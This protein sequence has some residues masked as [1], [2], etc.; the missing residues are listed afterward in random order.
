MM[1]ANA[2]AR[3]RGRRDAPPIAY[4]RACRSPPPC[5]MPTCPC[6]PAALAAALSDDAL[7]RASNATIHERG[8]AYAAAGA[9][10]DLVELPGER[11]GVHATVEGSEAYTTW[12]WLADGTVGGRCSCPNAQDRGFCK[13]QVALALVWRA[14]LGGEAAE[15]DPAAQK[16][17]AAAA[18][19]AQTV[20]DRRQALADFLAA[21]PAQALAERL[22]ALADADREIAAALQQWRQLAQ[23]PSRAAD[24]KPLVTELLAPGRG[25]LDRRDSRVFA[26]RARGV[27]PLLAQAQ[28]RDPAGA[29]ALALHA[30]RR[31]WLVLSERADDSDGE[32]GD[33]VRAIGKAWVE[34]LKHAGPHPAA[35]GDT[36]LQVVLDD[37]FGCFDTPQAAA[38]IGPAAQQ[39]F[40]QA[41]AARWQAS[42]RDAAP[43]GATTGFDVQRW[44]VERL[45]LEQLDAEGDVDGALAVLRSDLSVPNAYRR[46]T[47]LL[48]HH[49]RLREA[50][51]NAEQGCRAFPRDPGL[52]EDLLSAYERDGW[53][54]EAL[55]LHRRRFDAA[56]SP[57]RYHAL[58][59]AAAAA[60]HDVAALREALLAAV[61]AQERRATSVGAPRFHPPGRAPAPAA[62]MFR[63]VTLR[64]ALLCSEQRWSEALALVQPPAVCATTLLV[65]LADGLGDGDTAARIALLQRAFDAEMAVATSPYRT[66]LARV[67]QIAALMAAP[68]RAA[69]LAL[70]R[71]RH[72][73]KRN[74]VQG[75]PAA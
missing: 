60:G 67:A 29:P 47:A 21:Q 18:K 36:L 49:G 25:F 50:F 54:E 34:A 5:P 11:P 73:A 10:V 68:E 62:P 38:A 13:H 72:K 75:L 35:F 40:R 66:P 23:A 19:R 26:Q 45:H 15:P 27:L 71:Q 53:H 57:E 17:A 2:G 8:R 61:E 31:G 43:R 41:V 42:V 1:R 55:A 24:L 48:L 22:L 12:V 69:W 58:L 20:R 65:R 30:M 74:F 4:K 6:A 63:D 56:P 14:R 46:V 64:A 7:R 37:P 39:R 3:H 28:A 59:R 44:Q 16:K 9:V 33:V 52:Q 51:A 32:I 70:L